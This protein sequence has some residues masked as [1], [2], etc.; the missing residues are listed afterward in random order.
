[1]KELVKQLALEEQVYIDDTW[2]WYEYGQKSD[3]ALVELE[4]CLTLEVPSVHLHY[5]RDEAELVRQFVHQHFTYGLSGRRIFFVLI[6]ERKAEI[7]S[8][9]S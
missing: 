1:M 9:I 3:F 7:R 6:G 8:L 5:C 2:N 4:Y